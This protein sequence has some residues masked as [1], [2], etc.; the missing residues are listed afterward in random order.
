MSEAARRLGLTGVEQ[1]LPTR[2]AASWRC[3]AAS[4]CPSR[5]AS[6]SPWSAP[7]APASRPCCTSPDFWRRPD[8]GEI[9]VDG[10]ACSKL[11]DNDRT[12]LRRNT[13]GFVYQYH[14]LLPEFSALENLVVPQMIS[15]IPR[16]KAR[17]R[18]RELLGM[19]GLL[20]REDHRPAR[21]S[22][23]EQQRVAIARALANQPKIL[24]A[25]EPTGNLDPHTADTVFDIMVRLVRDA[26]LAGLIATH[27]MALASRMDRNLR[28]EDGH[29]VAA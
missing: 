4:S 15:G 22:G 20:E 29:V 9:V 8:A 16:S 10:A 1:D 28:L 7:R 18:A 19:V 25:D 23:G 2:P 5:R 12:A 3:C 24:L 27:N 11:S 14:H 17:A 21:L 26:G 6:W 13:V